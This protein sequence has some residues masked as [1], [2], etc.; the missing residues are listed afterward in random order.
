MTLAAVAGSL[1]GK[2]V[3]DRLSGTTLTQ[4]F[5]VLL[6]AVAVYTGTDSILGLAG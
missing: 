1:A 3:A 4:A 5:A 6:I 2:K